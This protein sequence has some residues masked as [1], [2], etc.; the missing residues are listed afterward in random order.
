LFENIVLRQSGKRILDV[1]IARPATEKT[2]FAAV[3]VPLGRL[4]LAGLTL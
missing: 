2:Y 4:L 1:S 3:T